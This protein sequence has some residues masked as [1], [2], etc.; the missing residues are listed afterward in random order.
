MTAARLKHLVTRNDVAEACGVSGALVSYAFSDNAKNKVKSATREKILRTAEAMGYQ[1]S[2]IG[3][4]LKTRRSYNVALLLPEQFASGISLHQLRIFHGV[5]L[6]MQ[7]TDY[8]PMV[9]FGVN[10]K[11][12]RTLRERRVDGIILLDSANDLDYI[13]EL[14]NF[15]RPL[16]LANVEYRLDSPQVASVRSDHEGIVKLLFRKLVGNNCR[17][18]LLVSAPGDLCQ[19]NWILQEAFRKEAEIY[20]SQGISAISYCPDGY[21]VNDT[22]RA[23][24][25]KFFQQPEPVDGVLVDGGAFADMVVEIAEQNG[26]KLIRNKNCFVTCSQ[27]NNFPNWSQ[28]S[29][30]VGINA[31][32]AMQKI[33]NGEP[34]MPLLK[35]PYFSAGSE[36]DLRSR[37]KHLL[38]CRECQ[39]DK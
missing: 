28:D 24:V 22:M 19:P 29:F 39:V 1:P 12:F 2:L 37:G 17:K 5:C 36:E 26:V 18:I 27:E 9:F 23:Q 8:R 15:N 25:G 21:W 32:S 35:I 13:K 34:Q 31:W 4:S 38:S 11:F 10:D 6:A 14:V 7:E 33:L 3:R 20:S 30:G 16:V